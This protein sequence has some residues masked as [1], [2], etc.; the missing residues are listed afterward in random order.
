MANTYSNSQ[1]YW[2]FLL[3]SVYRY[4]NKLNDKTGENNN[5]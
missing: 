5:S 4:F 2:C 3:I 1:G